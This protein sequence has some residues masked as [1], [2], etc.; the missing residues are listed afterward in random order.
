VPALA[1]FSLPAN[2]RRRLRFFTLEKIALPVLIRPLR[3]LVRSWRAAGPGAVDLREAAA[4][5]RLILAT[6]HGMLLHL[7]AYAPIVFKHGRRPVVLVSPSLDGRLL[8]TTLAYFGIDHVFGTSNSRGVSGARRFIA[9]IAAGDVGIIAA[10][11]PRGPCG[12][13][14]PGVLEIAALAD[15]QITLVLTAARPGVRLRSW[16]RSQLPAPFA[17]IRLEARK[18]VPPP[19]STIQAQ[20]AVLQS[21]LSALAAAV[22]SQPLR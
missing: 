17:A 6:W 11:G 21:E 18:F 2:W 15:A 16:D 14:K 12:V 8:A 5:P 22:D 7:L 4:A 10:D 9:R 13:A 19:D 1:G 3:V 20:L